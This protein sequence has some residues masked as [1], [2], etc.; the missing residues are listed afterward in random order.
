MD[1]FGSVCDPFRMDT[2]RA[3]KQVFIFK[4]VPDP[5]LELVARAAEEM[6]VSG[7]E[8]IVSPGQSPGALFVIRSGTVRLAAE[9]RDRSPVL[10]GSGET[11]GD[12]PFVDGGPASLTAVALERV[13]LLVIRRKKLEEL[14][15]GKPEAAHHFYRAIAE[16]LAKRLRRAVDLLAFAT[17]R[18]GKS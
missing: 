8:T 15:A 3:L 14:F 17:E 12:V 5:V 11:I 18:E 10:F 2:L 1:R 16:S 9:Q 7:G 6:S 13:D 4:D